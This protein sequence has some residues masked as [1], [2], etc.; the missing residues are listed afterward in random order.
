VPLDREGPWPPTTVYADEPGL[1]PDDEWGE[2]FVFGDVLVGRYRLTARVDG[3]VVSREITVEEGR[4][5]F[6]VLSD[7]G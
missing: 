4:T 7:G 6:V 2:N 1:N 5:V 3:R